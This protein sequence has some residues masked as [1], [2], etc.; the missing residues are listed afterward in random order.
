MLHTSAALDNL[1]T[2][3]VAQCGR[4]YRVLERA[5][6]CM[7]IIDS[8]LC[9]RS[10]WMEG[11]GVCRTL[12]E[13]FFK[14]GAR[15]RFSESA[16]MIPNMPFSC[17]NSARH[18]SLEE[19]TLWNTFVLGNRQFGRL[20]RNSSFFFCRSCNCTDLRWYP[21][22]GN[23]R[24]RRINHMRPVRRVRVSW[25]EVGED[26]MLAHVGVSSLL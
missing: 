20:Q 6:A 7:T 12:A 13:I 19:L 21:G 16:V 23:A 9:C 4:I 1:H 14:N 25:S 10:H 15:T 26:E 18:K 17:D 22:N 3:A 11:H 5:Q 8:H 2:C 24:S